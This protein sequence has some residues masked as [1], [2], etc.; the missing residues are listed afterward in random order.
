M[1]NWGGRIAEVWQRGSR[2]LQGRDGTSAIL[3]TLLARFLIIFLNVATGT[4]TARL[5]GPSGRG[6]QAAMAIWPQF[7]AYSLSFG[8]PSALL[9]TL[10]KYP[11]ERSKSFSAA[12]LIG[13]ILSTIGAVIGIFTIPI[14]LRKYSVDTIHFA[15]ALMLAVPIAMFTEILRSSMEASDEFAI[16]NQ[17]RYV[18]PLGT[19]VM[20]VGLALLGKL[21]P[22][23]AVI[24]Y[25]LPGIPILVWMIAC[26]RRFFTIRFERVRR[27]TKRLLSYGLRAYGIDLVSTL[28][29]QLQQVLAVS[30]L[31]PAAMGLFAIAFSL[32]Q[33]L[34]VVQSSFVTVLFPKAAARPTEEVLQM[35]GRAARIGGFLAIVMA[36]FMMICAPLVLNLLYGKEYLAAIPVFRVLALETVVSGTS[37]ILAQ[38]FMALDRPGIVTV[39]QSLGLG[40]GIPLILWLTPSY[41][42]LGLGLALLCSALIRLA[43]TLICYPVVLKTAPP[44]LWFV[45]QDIE[46][47]RDKLY[48]R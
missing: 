10:K 46:F 31:V 33:L 20:L 39:I 15:Q 35:T 32:C 12:I 25:W 41:G 21:T 23:T 38:A 6:E 24:S 16:A 11:T 17:M 22:F 2:S 42:L 4:I 30:L 37:V 28:A 8:L 7:F 40:L 27:S 43:S 19:L 1:R 36:A 48:R 26:T 29:G 5:L 18:F 47:I 9:Y 44:S 34:Y 45:P 3:Q 14:L 13:V